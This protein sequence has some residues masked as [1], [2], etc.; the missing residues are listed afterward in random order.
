MNYEIKHDEDKVRLELVPASL[1]WAVG[2]IRTYGVQKYGDK[3]SWRQVEPD[4]YKGALLRH[5]MAYLGGEEID[6]ESGYPHLWHAACNI[7]FLIEMEG[8][9]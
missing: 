7:A 8:K 4:R 2:V 9:S 6:A 3:E 1:M 5:L